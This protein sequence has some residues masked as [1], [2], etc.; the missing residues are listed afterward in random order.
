MPH[1]DTRTQMAGFN[2]PS[3]FKSLLALLSMG[4]TGC[5]SSSGFVLPE[6]NHNALKNAEIDALMS[7]SGIGDC[8]A[9][10]C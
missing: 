4:A 5:K 2:D 7:Q 3:Y 10:F 6:L 8:R 9:K 1:T